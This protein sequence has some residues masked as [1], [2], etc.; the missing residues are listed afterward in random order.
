MWM[1]KLERRGE[2]RKEAVRRGDERRREVRLTL[3]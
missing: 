3:C 2:R 1:K